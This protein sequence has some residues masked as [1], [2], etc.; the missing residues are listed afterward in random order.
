MKVGEHLDDS[1]T[2]CGVL[3]VAEPTG[4]SINERK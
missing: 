2:H 1:G 3:I 4:V